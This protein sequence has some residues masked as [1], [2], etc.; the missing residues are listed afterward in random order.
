MIDEYWQS[1]PFGTDSIFNP[2]WDERQKEERVKQEE[3]NSNKDATNLTR[4]KWSKVYTG[5]PKNAS[6]T[7]DMAADAVF[8]SI[9]GDNYDRRTFTNACATRVSLGL[10]NGGINVKK[11]F[12][13]QKGD[14]KG[15][16]FITSAINLKNWLSKNEIFGVADEKIDGPSN[17]VDVRNIIGGRNGVYVILG[18]FA[19]GIT[20]HAT[21]WLGTNKDVVGGHNYVSYGGTIYFWEL[22]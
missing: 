16:G 1:S 2:S 10:L 5:Y 8:K 17:L 22:K 15:K 19:N 11:E 20:G 3:N 21:L 4:P 9:L 7:D 6:G 14:F 12:I 18:G 13:I